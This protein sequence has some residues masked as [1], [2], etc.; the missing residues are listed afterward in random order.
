MSEEKINY[1]WKAENERCSF[2][3]RN[4]ISGISTLHAIFEVPTKHHHNRLPLNRP[5]PIVG[6]LPSVFLLIPDP[7]TYHNPDL[8]SFLAVHSLPPNI[9]NNRFLASGQQRVSL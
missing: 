2:G 6:H 4:E 9:K 5:R 7:F 3:Y 1:V 8:V